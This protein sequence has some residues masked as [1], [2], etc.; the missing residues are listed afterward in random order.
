MKMHI[1]EIVAFA[2]RASRL[3]DATSLVQDPLTIVFREG[4]P[5]ADNI[6]YE[7]PGVCSVNIDVDSVGNVVDIEIY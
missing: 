7:V 3:P 6:E 4:I 1:S 2:R 5:I